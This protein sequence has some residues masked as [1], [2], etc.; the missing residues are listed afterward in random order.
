MTQCPGLEDYV[1]HFGGVTDLGYLR[2]HYARFCMTKQFVFESELP[3]PQTMLDI[4]SHWLHHTL[5][6]ALDGIAVTASDL[7]GTFEDATV[8]ILA[9]AHGITLYPFK[10][11]SDPHVFDALPENG[12]D[13]VFFTEILEHIT[14]NPVDM[15]KAIYRV[16]H[17]GGRIILTTP[18]YYYIGGWFW[19]FKRSI[20][21]TG[22]GVSVHEILS[23]FTNG[24]HW[25]E[26]S[27]REIRLYFNL[28]S[29]DFQVRRLQY[30]SIPYFPTNTFKEKLRKIAE[31]HIRILRNN[32]FAE[33]GLPTKEHGITMV[34]S[35]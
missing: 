13:L 34:P 3:K 25:K 2:L 16:L 23:K 9:Q 1:Q 24:P 14:F 10:D 22:G 5:L 21:R 6:Y 15:W 26:Y 8:C 4:G 7:P 32:I 12:F 17:P 19:D 27:A 30:V 33:I 29:P 20:K 18:N 35:W 28:L 31:R 11:L